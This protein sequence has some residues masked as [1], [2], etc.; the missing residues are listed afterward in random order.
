MNLISI[1]LVLASVI[2]LSAQESET[3]VIS[4]LVGKVNIKTQADNKWKPLKKEDKVSS[5]DS[6]MTGNGSIATLTY[7][8]S[9]F[10]IAANSSIVVNSLYTKENDGSIAVQNGSAW[11]K[12]KDLGGKKFIAT[13]PTSTA[14]VRGT[15]FGAIYDAKTNSSMHC[16]CEGK[17]E[18]TTATTGAKPKLVE[19]GNG[20]SFQK[21]NADIAMS[22]Y[23]NLIVKNEAMPE[24]ESKVKESPMLKTCLSCH[25]PKG[26]TTSGIMKDD[27]YGK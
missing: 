12:V 10:K 1:V 25:T 22:S 17:I 20:S 26:W 18:V 3:A 4:L 6:I 24:F 21:D 7:K 2:S 15:A 23:K 9:E 5:G 27:K 16:V 8:G 14:G 13:T 11:F 19:K